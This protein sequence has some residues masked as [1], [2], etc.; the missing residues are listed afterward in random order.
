LQSLLLLLS[1]NRDGV[2]RAAI[3]MGTS[4]IHGEV[5]GSSVF[6]CIFTYFRKGE[7]VHNVV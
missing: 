5:N 2:R 3:V 6:L 7:K 4:Y 1:C